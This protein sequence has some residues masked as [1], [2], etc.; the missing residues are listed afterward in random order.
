VDGYNG[1]YGTVVLN[2]SL[3]VPQL[4]NLTTAQDITDG[5]FR[6]RLIGQPD[7]NFAIEASTNLIGWIPLQT[8]QATNGQFDFG[9]T[10]LSGSRERFYRA[11]QLSQ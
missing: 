5:Q 2:I 11:R 7:L 4:I 1:D 10:N 8:N 6:L 3:N 9:D